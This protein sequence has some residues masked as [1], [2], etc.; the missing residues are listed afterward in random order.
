MASGQWFEMAKGVAGDCAIVPDYTVPYTPRI[1]ESRA[2]RVAGRLF[3]L[4]CLAVQYAYCVCGL[5][6]SVLYDSRPRPLD[7]ETW[8]ERAHSK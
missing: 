3:P 5:Q 1:G 4:R 7:P 2:L 6:Q 8:S